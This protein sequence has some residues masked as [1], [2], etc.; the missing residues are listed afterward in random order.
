MAEASDLIRTH[1]EQIVDIEHKGE[2]D[3]VTEADR[4]CERLILDRLHRRFPTHS[5]IGEEGCPS[6][7][8]GHS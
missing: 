6:R 3:L 1:F 7:K 2:F 4:S 5:V 8:L